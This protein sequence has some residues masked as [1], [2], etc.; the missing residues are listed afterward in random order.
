MDLANGSTL[1]GVSSAGTGRPGGSAASGGTCGLN[2]SGSGRSSGAKMMRKV[3]SMHN[4]AELNNAGAEIR[5]RSILK[6]SRSQE[7]PGEG[8]GEG[9][10]D[11]PAG[12]PPEAQQ[13][14]GGKSPMHSAA[15]PAV[16]PAGG[17]RRA[18]Q[19]SPNLEGLMRQS[20]AQ[21]TLKDPST[22]RKSI[23]FSAT[24]TMVKIDSHNDLSKCERESIYYDRG[25]MTSFVRSELTRRKVKGITSTSALAPEAEKVGEIDDVETPLSF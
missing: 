24:Q 16:R 2:D 10:G 20:Q 23:R 18:A 8:P 11:E 19:S 14:P 21:A 22:P 5:L 7:G 4:F 17:M 9:A 25:D 13:G 3:T 6:K 15:S 12:P 1:T